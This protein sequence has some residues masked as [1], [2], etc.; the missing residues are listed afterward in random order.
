MSKGQKGPFFQP[1]WGS[2]KGSAS[3]GG[4][5]P[6]IAEA[7]REIRAQLEAQ[8]GIGFVKI[9]NWKGRF[10][11]SLGGF[12]EFLQSRPDKFT[13][14]PGEGHNFTVALANNSSV[15]TK[16]HAGSWDAPAAK[17]ARLS[18]E[19]LADKAVAEITRQLNHPKN[20]GNVWI[21]SWNREYKDLLG[22]LRE[23]LESQPD[24][25]TVIPVNEKKYT[26]SL[27]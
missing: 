15:G 5:D 8:G 19:A 13:V 25:F 16:R 14:V 17:Q 2:G 27:V 9:D 11:S 22:T 4:W 6:S 26:V 1:A 18:P 3:H 24:M 7:I 20:T 23:F 10:A 12:R 21:S